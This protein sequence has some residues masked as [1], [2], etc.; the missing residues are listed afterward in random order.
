MECGDRLRRLFS[1]GFRRFMPLYSRLCVE[2]AGGKF[3]EQFARLRCDA[4][5]ASFSEAV[6]AA[7]Q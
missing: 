4:S 3:H 2:Y 6:V 1:V 5:A 7:E